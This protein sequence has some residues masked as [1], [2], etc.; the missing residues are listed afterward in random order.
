MEPEVADSRPPSIRNK[1]DL[2]QPERPSSTTNS[3]GTMSRSMSR[4]ASVLRPAVVYVLETCSIRMPLPLPRELRASAPAVVACGTGSSMLAADPHG[5][6][7][8]ARLGQRTTVGRRGRTRERVHQFHFGE[9][10]GPH[11]FA[12]IG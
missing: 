4:S 6:G 8:G 2:P 3:P 11:L 10:G 9:T 1:V 12:Q 5:E 7:V